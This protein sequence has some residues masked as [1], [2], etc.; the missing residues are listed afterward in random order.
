MQIDLGAQIETAQLKQ[1]IENLQKE[2]EMI[3]NLIL[4]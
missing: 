1:E 4:M 2:K 3:K